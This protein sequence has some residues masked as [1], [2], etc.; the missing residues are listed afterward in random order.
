MQRALVY[1]LVISGV[2]AAYLIV[3]GA[4]GVTARKVAVAIPLILLFAGLVWLRWD[5]APKMAKQRQERKQG[6][7]QD[8]G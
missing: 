4:D 3:R 8:H 1:F 7:A 2:A 5:I 6:N